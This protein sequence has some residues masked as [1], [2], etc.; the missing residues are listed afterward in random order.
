MELNCMKSLGQESKL[1]TFNSVSHLLMR[2]RCLKH[3]ALA[4]CFKIMPCK[5]IHH[6]QYDN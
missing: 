1:A 3:I 6:L 5:F 4:K 2:K